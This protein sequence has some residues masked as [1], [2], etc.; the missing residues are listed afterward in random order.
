MSERSFAAASFVAGEFR[1]GRIFGRSMTILLQNFLPFVLLTGLATS[2]NLLLRLGT[3][4]GNHPISAGVAI[5]LQVILGMLSQGFVLFGAFQSMLGRPVRAGKSLRVALA[6]FFPIIGVSICVGFA[7]VIGFVLLI[8]PGFILITILF[9]AV[10][11]CVVDRLGPF[12]SMA[13][14][15]DLTKG[16]RW[17][18]FGIFL[19]LVLVGLIATALVTVVLLAAGGRSVAAAGSWVWQA[20]F[21][22]F[23][24][25]LYVVIY[26]D[27]RVAKEG[28][29]TDQIAAVF[30]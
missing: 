5:I 1:I 17:K 11:A 12:Q 13:R 30:E 29:D 6:R 2:P 8:V 9:V 22:A 21:G 4:G 25:I 26:H 27:L 3:A 28:V 15:A 23:S 19:L 10:P 18:I 14:S 24:A 20:V 7:V 16:H